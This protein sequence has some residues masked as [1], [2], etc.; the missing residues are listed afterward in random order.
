MRLV[1][2]KCLLPDFSIL[3]HNMEK[4]QII[5]FVA[6]VFLNQFDQ[7]KMIILLMLT[8]NT[9]GKR[10]QFATKHAIS[11]TLGHVHRL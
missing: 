1:D 7:I 9:F 10:R 4:Y 6:S 3:V 8:I 5:A 2:L 11:V